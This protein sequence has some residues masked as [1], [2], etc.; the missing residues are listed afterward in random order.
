[1]H[2]QAHSYTDAN[3]I[4]QQLR[5]DHQP[6]GPQ[7]S[8]AQ[9]PRLEN[10]FLFSGHSDSEQC[11][12]CGV[13]SSSGG[14]GGGERWIF[15]RTCAESFHHSCA[16]QVP[17]LEHPTA[18]GVP[19]GC[20][21][22][23]NWK[24]SCCTKCDGCDASG[25]GVVTCRSCGSS[26]CEKCSPS[27]PLSV[28][29]YHSCEACRMVKPAFCLN[30]T[31]PVG[32][33]GEFCAECAVLPSC[34][35]CLIR[36]RTDEEVLLGMVVCDSCGIYTH[37]L[38]AG[39][40]KVHG[41]FLCVKCVQRKM[42]ESSGHCRKSIVSTST[43][44]RYKDCVW[45]RSSFSFDPDGTQKIAPRAIS[46]AKAL[47]SVWRRGSVSVMAPLPSAKNTLV[48][49]RR[50]WSYKR[51][52]HR[53]T[54]TIVFYFDQSW[55]SCS[56]HITAQDDV[57]AKYPAWPLHLAAL[58]YR[59]RWDSRFEILHSA[60]DSNLLAL[61]IVVEFVKYFRATCQPPSLKETPR[62]ALKHAEPQETSK[63]LKLGEE[64]HQNLEGDREIERRGKKRQ[65]RGKKQYQKA[66]RPKRLK[67]SGKRQ[68]PQNTEDA[69]RLRLYVKS[70]RGPV[71][72]PIAIEPEREAKP[73][74]VPAGRPPSRSD[75]LD[76]FVG[77][78]RIAGYGLYA[79]Q[80]VPLGAKVIE[81][82]GEVVGQVV[83]DRR[84]KLY[85][86]LPLRRN[87]CYLFRL[88]ADRIIDATLKANRARFINHSCSPNC[89]T[90]I[91]DHGGEKGVV[92]YATRDIQ[93]GEELTYDYKFS[94][95]DAKDM[96]A[97]H[98]GAGQ[99]RKWMN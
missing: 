34:P 12:E 55:H 45:G 22:C 19:P 13:F 46:S 62:P 31:S 88:E 30:C 91:V 48:V 79:G 67:K 24:C 74:I 54:L 71:G 60:T 87:D 84:E 73:K 8:H 10:E 38:C 11:R 98:C 21:P 23:W 6:G 97:C 25:D 2:V 69:A 49:K 99:C 16:K 57:A 83:A 17:V 28:N 92:I 39:I 36:Y 58:Q 77:K 18:G 52:R 44:T 64:L 80:D 82:C 96:A 66:T 40:N 33:S 7:Q 86:L 37:N 90:K 9:P 65:A 50:Y 53:T 61:P 14:D 42:Q 59:K 63:P 76:L 51:E 43:A 27:P 26:V 72:A 3:A 56:V 32:K 89:E 75:Q 93:K 41:C 29:F 5:Q 95:E 94:S 35:R 78:S 70:G 85:S 20:F 1:M 68:Q 4:K 15:C 81:Y 47:G